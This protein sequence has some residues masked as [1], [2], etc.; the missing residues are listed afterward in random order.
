MT[1][2]IEEAGRVPA[3]MMQRVDVLSSVADLLISRL[4]E[5]RKVL[6][7]GNGGSA[8]EASHL[9]EELVGRFRADRRALPAVCLCADAAALTCIANDWDYAE[10]FARQVEA[11]GAAGDVLIA[12]STSGRSPSIV[13]ALERGRQRGLTTVGLLGSAGSPAQPLCDL[14][15]TLDGLSAA[16]VQEAHLLA[17][18]LLLEQIDAA[19]AA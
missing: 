16:R 2:A 6:T 3:L 12:L 18:H 10:V 5:E 1:R 8:A 15:L 4:R 14:S 7:C 11:H 9:A 17:I 13:R 19:F